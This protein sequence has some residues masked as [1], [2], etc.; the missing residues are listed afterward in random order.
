MTNAGSRRLIAKFVDH[1]FTFV[2]VVMALLFVGILWKRLHVKPDRQATADRQS[3]DVGKNFGLRDID[4]AL[5]GRTLLLVLSTN[6]H[7]C[8]ESAPF[9]QQIVEKLKTTD[10]KVVALFP[11]TVSEGKQYLQDLGVAI[12]EVRQVDFAS[13]GLSKTPT[14]MIVNDKGIV[15]EIWVGKLGVN[16]QSAVLER[17]ASNGESSNRLMS[18]SELLE[19]MRTDKNLVIVDVESRDQFKQEHIAG[20]R[21]IPFDELE[22]RLGNEI[23][24]SA[25]VVV[26]D[27]DNLA[28]LSHHTLE[29]FVEN[30]IT[31]VAVLS[32]GYDGWKKLSGFS[33]ND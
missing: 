17:L 15:G 3:I 32:G 9:Y 19:A 14:L 24:P 30:G 6:C 26:Y 23:S 27:H 29:V 25:R 18:G 8:S 2:L 4:W 22:T 28:G 31:N 20:A 13:L 33:K 10:I 11:Q 7:F 12:G 5:N 1:T 16:M 21:N